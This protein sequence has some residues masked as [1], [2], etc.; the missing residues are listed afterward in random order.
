MRLTSDHRLAVYGTLAP[1]EPNHHQMDGMAGEWSPGIVRGRLFMVGW[2]GE[3]GYP[4]IE[5]D[6]DG[7][8][9]SVQVFESADLPDHWERLDRFEGPGYQRVAVEVLTAAGPIEAQI[10][11]LV[12][13]A[14]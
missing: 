10:Y 9:V 8:E 3:M 1:D 14:R 4:G 2:G 11:A 12:P 13:D 5:L 7:Q 6:P